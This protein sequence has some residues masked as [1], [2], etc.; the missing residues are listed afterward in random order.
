[1]KKYDVKGYWACVLRGENKRTKTIFVHRLVALMFIPNPENK[2]QVNH[3]NGIKNDNRL[4]NL[5][6]C[7]PKENIQHALRTGLMRSQKRKVVQMNKLGEVVRRH[8]S[9]SS[10]VIYGFNPSAIRHVLVG[11]DG[12]KYHKGFMWKYAA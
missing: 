1:M 6:W 3:I 5:E 2:T 11:S 10:T 4:E 8:E 7:T 9:I 12:R